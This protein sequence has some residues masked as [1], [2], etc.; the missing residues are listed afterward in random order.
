MLG[1]VGSCFL[2]RSASNV[3]LFRSLLVFSRFLGCQ[4]SGIRFVF[5][6]LLDST[7][8]ITVPFV[9]CQAVFLNALGLL[10]HLCA[11][12]SFQVSLLP[13]GC[14]LLCTLG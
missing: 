6:L 7:L 4:G 10:S 1:L 11:A 13:G 5:S 8:L 14:L 2:C 12:S 3:K 9:P